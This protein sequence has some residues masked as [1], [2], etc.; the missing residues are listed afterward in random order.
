MRLG[1]SA[2]TAEFSATAHQACLSLA[3]AQ[4]E[5]WRNMGL[6]NLVDNT[7]TELGKKISDGLYKMFEYGVDSLEDLVSSK[8]EF[9]R[10]CDLDRA[11]VLLSELD[12]PVLTGLWEINTVQA[13][14]D[15]LAHNA[16]HMWDPH[17]LADSTL[18]YASKHQVSVS[19][20]DLG[21]RGMP[22][23]ELDE[24]LTKKVA[25][26]LNLTHVRGDRYKRDGL[27]VNFI[28]L[29]ET[30]QAFQLAKVLNIGV[31][32]TESC[33]VALSINNPSLG[34]QEELRAHG[35][36]SNAAA[37]RAI[38]VLAEHVLRTAPALYR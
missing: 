23:C 10:M 20:A 2:G 37:R 18:D 12:D 34:H 24:A 28:P 26:A 31:S 33:V 21:E 38:V 9:T 13:M 14:L 7:R 30:S 35:G 3:T 6:V 8:R 19:P 32:T 11:Q 1:G 29:Q 17:F 4:R 22:F 36:D 15:L 5:F 25:R 27:D 16:L